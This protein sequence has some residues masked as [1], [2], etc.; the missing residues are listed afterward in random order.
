MHIASKP[1]LLLSSFTTLIISI[2]MLSARVRSLS[3][4]ATKSKPLHF[5]WFRQDLRLHDNPALNKCIQNSNKSS[6]NDVST[7]IVPIYCFD[8][9]FL[10]GDTMTK[11]G[12]QKCGV[13]RAK[14]LLESV[15]DLRSNLE[16]KGSGLMVAYGHTEDVMAKLCKA[17]DDEVANAEQGAGIEPLV[18]V[19]E[20][21]SSQEYKVDKSVKRAVKTF[22]N[23]ASGSLE[24]VWAATLYDIDDLPFNDGVSGMPD[25]FTPFRNKV[26][27]VC[28]RL[29][30]SIFPLEAASFRMR[31][32]QKQ[33]THILTFSCLLHH[34]YTY[35]NTEL[36]NSIS[37]PSPTKDTTRHAQEPGS[38]IRP[39]RR[40]TE[41]NCH[42][43]TFLHANPC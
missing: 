8:P 37:S 2:L 36:Q 6:K 12:S 3:M 30:S 29:Q 27:K 43:L 17:I 7:G 9:R 28:E 24:T 10:G 22:K 21:P 38:H 5:H 15:E 34:L 4:S 25:T 42:L 39:Q 40:I 26:E 16:K 32:A 19:Q 11:F 13:M 18:S 1:S 31:T 41:C 20:E 23:N 33:K 14:F 35:H